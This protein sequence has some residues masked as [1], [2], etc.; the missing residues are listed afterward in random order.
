M[1]GLNEVENIV[2]T[3][4]M[5]SLKRVKILAKNFHLLLS[6]TKQGYLLDPPESAL[7][8]GCDE[9][10]LDLFKSVFDQKSFCIVKIYGDYLFCHRK[11]VLESL[12]GGTF[13]IV[14]VT[15]DPARMADEKFLTEFSEKLSK[16]IRDERQ[17]LLEV[18]NDWNGTTLVGILLGYPV[19]YWYEE[20]ALT[21]LNN[22]NLCV[23]EVLDDDNFVVLKFSYPQSLDQE[24]N[25]ISWHRE[26]SVRK[27]VECHSAINL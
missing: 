19:V 14:N 12:K 22:V 11:S 3:I 25:I 24:I 15:S 20:T 21:C 6:E 17:I 4:L 2:K 1:R 9:I 26:L 5:T 18:R 13:K 10:A 27:F 8:R 23:T 16:R 7:L